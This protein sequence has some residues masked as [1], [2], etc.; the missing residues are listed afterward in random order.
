MALSAVADATNS[1]EGR[2]YR[3]ARHVIHRRLQEAAV[4]S[5]YDDDFNEKE[6]LASQLGKFPACHVCGGTATGFTTTPNDIFFPE[7]SQ[8]LTCQEVFDFAAG[9]AIPD[10]ECTFFQEF[11][12]FECGCAASPTISPAPTVSIQ[13]SAN[14]TSTPYPSAGPCYFC[15]AEDKFISWDSDKTVDITG[16]FGD[17]NVPCFFMQDFALYGIDIFNEQFPSCEAYQALGEQCGCPPIVPTSSPKPTTS[18]RPSSAP[19]VSPAPTT[20]PCYLCGDASVQIP[21][22]KYDVNVNMP[23]LFDDDFSP[24]GESSTPCFVLQ[25]MAPYFAF[26]EEQCSEVQTFAKECGCPNQEPTVSPRPTVTPSPTTSPTA[27]PAPSAPCSCQDTCGNNNGACDC[28]CDSVCK[29]YGDCCADVS[30]HCNFW[31]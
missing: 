3:F 27:S 24:T 11:F 19:S 30:D 12:L 17:E 10:F 2:K 14:P 29:E 20:S 18:P 7:E 13:P 21:F 8:D 22:D 4:E 5:T 25:D 23:N 31:D 6:W 9:G 15:G 1:I 28:W 16:P 26:T